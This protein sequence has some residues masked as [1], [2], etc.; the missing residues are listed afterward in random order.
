MTCFR[1]AMKNGTLSV[2]DCALSCATSFALDFQVV[3]LAAGQYGDGSFDM[4]GPR[5]NN[6][7]KVT[8]SS[9]VFFFLLDVS[10]QPQAI[11]MYAQ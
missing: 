5:D 10:E 8:Y 6:C 9:G 1:I 2:V 3:T 7:V 4:S 11:P